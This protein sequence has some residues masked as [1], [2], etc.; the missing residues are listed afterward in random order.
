MDTDPRSPVV[1]APHFE[2]LPIDS[3]RGQIRVLRI[4]PGKAGET[5]EC[6]YEIVNVDDNV[7]YQTLSYVWGS[8]DETRTAII[9]G[10]KADLTDNLFAALTRIRHETE[11][12]RLWV[13]A[14]C[15][16]QANAAEKM[17]QVNMMRSIYSN[18]EECHIWMGNINYAAIGAAEPEALQAAQGALDAIRIMAGEVFETLPPHLATEDRRDKAGKALKALMHTAWWGRIWTVQEATTPRNAIVHWGPLAIPWDLMKKATVALMQ[19]S[20]P[21]HIYHMFMCGGSSGFFTAPI[22]GLIWASKWVEQPDSPLWMLYR[23]RY[24]DSTDPRDKIYVVLNL[25]ADGTYPLPSVTSSDYAIN[26]AVLYRNVMLDLL[27]SE[28]GL[29]PMIGLRGERKSVPGLPSWVVDWSLPPPG[30]GIARFWEHDKFWPNYTADRGLPMLDLDAL[31][32]P[33]HG[34]DV[35]NVN[36]VFFD[37]ILAHSD[38]LAEGEENSRLYEIADDLVEKTLAE[39]LRDR[40]KFEVYWRESL[41]DIIEGEHANPQQSFDGKAAD[42]Y[43]RELMLPN[44]RLFIAESGVVGLGPSGTSVGDEI[45]V[46]SGGRTPFLLSPLCAGDGDDRA[47]QKDSGHY[48]FRGDVFVLKIMRGKAVDGNIDRQR[49]VHIH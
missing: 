21:L 16:N 38:L 29:R 4:A 18:C 41:A 12:R 46:L 10:T 44:Q 11:T 3:S 37:K 26:T 17:A 19:G 43:W 13:D 27:R 6:S 28:W 40:G 49:F 30:L 31:T 25:V 7:P 5:I 8:M 33:E 39:D 35:L 32:S 34:E 22:L 36:G 48:T 15:I 9:E 1:L 2:F 14:L 42:V 45:W 47:D 24:R 20:C 23:F